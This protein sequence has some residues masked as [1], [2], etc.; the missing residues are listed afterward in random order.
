MSK[1]L[2]FGPE[3]DE[4]IVEYLKEESSLKQK[5]IVFRDKI[6][7]A[8]E[9]LA[10]YHYH[11]FPVTRNEEIIS[12]C[13]AF[14]YEQIRKFDF[15]NNKRGFPYFNIIAK[16]FFIGK[17]KQQNKESANNRDMVVSLQDS[18]LATSDEFFDEDFEAKIEDNQFMALFEEN[19]AQWQ[20]KFT[21]DHEKRVVD[22]L[23]DL[24]K[25]V[26]NIDIIK[27]KAVFLYLKEQT[28]LN[29]KQI[30][31]NLNKIKKKFHN[32]KKKYDRG[33]F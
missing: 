7:P 10:T 13:I 17:L 33:D 25:N 19:L 20:D 21:K 5:S 1:E 26:E 6:Y 30:A 8:F 24:F 23:V 15:E 31:I 12:E 29:S 11:K 4:A 2:Y 28:G 22:A 14:L 27:K 32:L 3:V 16:H 9:K 18:K